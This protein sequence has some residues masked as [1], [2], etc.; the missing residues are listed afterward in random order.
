MAEAPDET[1]VGVITTRRLV[2]GL[3]AMVVLVLVGTIIGLIWADTSDVA[4]TIAVV[5]NVVG[6]AAV[7][8]LLLMLVVSARRERHA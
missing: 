1:I 8:V 3:A 5:T 7:V 2:Y 6:G 4:G